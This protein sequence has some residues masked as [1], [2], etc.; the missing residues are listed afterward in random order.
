MSGY[1]S[2]GSRDDPAVKNIISVLAEDPGLAPRTNMD[3]I[4]IQAKHSYKDNILWNRGSHSLMNY[5]A[6]IHDGGY[7]YNNNK[8]P[9]PNLIGH[10]GAH[11]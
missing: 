9:K 7:Q 8:N 11:Q 3:H 4:S 5:M 1:F 2:L 6:R 10:G